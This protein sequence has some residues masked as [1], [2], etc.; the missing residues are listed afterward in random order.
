MDYPDY[1]D[2]IYIKVDAPPKCA[3][4]PK[5]IFFDGHP[6]INPCQRQCQV[7]RGF[8]PPLVVRRWCMLGSWCLILGCCW[9]DCWTGLVL[10]SDWCPLS[11]WFDFWRYKGFIRAVLEIIFC[12]R[13][14]NQ[15]HITLEKLKT[16]QLILAA[17]G[18]IQ[19]MFQFLALSASFISL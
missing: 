2:N 11:R 5:R 9:F 6:G 17:F 7:W 18:L 12:L 4:I 15:I 16:G 14:W 8:E 3:Y 13:P 1:P 19:A 10:F